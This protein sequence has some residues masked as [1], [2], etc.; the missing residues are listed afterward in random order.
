[1]QAVPLNNHSINSIDFEILRFYTL[2]VYSIG[3]L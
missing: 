2:I 1:L 3:F